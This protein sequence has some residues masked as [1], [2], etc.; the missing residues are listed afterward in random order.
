LHALYSEGGIYLDT[1]VQVI[2]DFAPLL[3]KKCF[4][5]FQQEEEQVDWVNSAILGAEREHH[6]LKQ[7][8][9][10]TQELFALTGVFPRSPAV[11][12]TVL[13]GMG[14][15]DYVVQEVK[16][17]TVYPAEYFY[18]YPWFGKFTPACLTEK[19]YCI[20]HW[21]WSWRKKN[22]NPVMS[23][24]RAIKKMVLTVMPKLE[25]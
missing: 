11:F 24:L 5:G 13:K 20:H 8:M 10:L 25:Q 18:P 15:K 9:S 17:V 23:S 3:V 2:K 14:L 4:L 21:E 16:D 6:F 12:T 22:H 1:D 7:C 19:T